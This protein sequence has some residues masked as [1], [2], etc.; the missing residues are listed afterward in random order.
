MRTGIGPEPDFDE[1]SVLNYDKTSTGIG[2]EHDFENYWFFGVPKKCTGIGPE[3]DFD[4][5][6][7]FEVSLFMRSPSRKRYDNKKPDS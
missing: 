5:K 2:P 7:I 6:I 1:N 4:K 3:R